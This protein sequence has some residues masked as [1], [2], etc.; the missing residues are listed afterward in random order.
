MSVLYT[1]ETKPDGNP[2]LPRN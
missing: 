2:S 1:D